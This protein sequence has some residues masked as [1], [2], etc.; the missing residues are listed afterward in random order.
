MGVSDGDLLEV[1]VHRGSFVLRPKTLFDRPQ[2]DDDEYTPA[3][4]RIIDAR[5]AKAHADVKA[6]H[7][8]RPFDTHE[9]FIADLH[10]EANKYRRKKTKLSGR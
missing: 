8:S 10:K 4:R 3:Q 7:V 9:E 2:S 1:R 6:G 5:L